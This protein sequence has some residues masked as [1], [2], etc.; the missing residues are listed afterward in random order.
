MEINKY[1][2]LIGMSKDGYPKDCGVLQ[3]F[4]Q[5]SDTNKNYSTGLNGEYN[6]KL[7]DL[8]LIGGVSNGEY[9]IQMISSTVKLDRGN[10]NDNYKFQHISGQN[11]VANPI[12]FYDCSV[13]NWIDIDFATIGGVGAN[14]NTLPPSYNII[15][16]FEYERL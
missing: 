15:L 7:L 8:K 10:L 11:T 1:K 9:F 13:K 3:I 6:L 2:P 4:W 5:N 12:M 14:N 16:T